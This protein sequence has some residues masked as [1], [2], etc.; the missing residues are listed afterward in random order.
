MRVNSYARDG[1]LKCM[2]VVLNY[3]M[4]LDEYFGLCMSNKVIISLFRAQFFG[5]ISIV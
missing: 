2:I 1:S 4:L 5:T 3:L